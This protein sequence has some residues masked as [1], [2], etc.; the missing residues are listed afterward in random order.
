MWVATT[1]WPPASGVGPC[2]E[3][4]LRPPKQAMVNWTT[5]PL[6][7]VPFVRFSSPFTFMLPTS[8]GSPWDSTFPKALPSSACFLS[9]THHTNMPEGWWKSFLL[10]SPSRPLSFPTPHYPLQLWSSCSELHYPLP[11]FVAVSYRT[12]VAPLTPED[13]NFCIMVTLALLLSY[14]LVISR[15]FNSLAFHFP[16]HSTSSGFLL[17]FNST[18]HST[19]YTLHRPCHCQ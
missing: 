5:R 19:G 7:P 1:A 15:P 9:H 14:C 13:F 17:N 6:G 10:T 18:T 4:K 3:T 11:L 2:Q 12:P 16:H 8:P